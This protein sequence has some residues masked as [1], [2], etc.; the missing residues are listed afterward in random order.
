MKL[1]IYMDYSATTPVDPRVAEKMIPYLTEKFGNPASRSHAFGWEADE[2]VE[3]A[4]A[5][6]AALVN[7]DP[8]EIVW[9]SGATESNNLAIKGAAHFYQGKGKHIVTMRIEHKAVIDTVRELEREGFSATYLDPEPSGLLDL[10]KF[11][12]ALRPDTVLV[13][14]M[15]VNNE[16]GVVQD[17]AALGEICRERGI[18]FHVDAAQATGKVD[19]DLQ[20]L[21][22]DLMSFSA[23][24]TYGPK[25][26]GAL[27]VRRKPRVRLEAQMHGGGHERGMRSGT[28]ATHQI[29][30]MGEAF[31]IAKEEMAQENER[32]RMLRDRLLKG[33]MTMEEVHI[34]GDMEHR[35]PHNLNLSFNFVEGESLIM[36]IKDVAVSSGSACTSASLEPSYVLR[37]LGRSDELAHS[38]IRFSV[39]RFTTVEEVDYVIE[40]LQGK[41]GKLR[42]LS[43]LWEMYKDGIDLNTVQ[44]AAH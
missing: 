37:A 3:Q 12:A 11:K 32:V 42:E 13:S 23:H 21:K 16:I 9:T 5:Q 18:L 29:V 25:G 41:I 14:I 20:Q 33:L 15:F 10:E 8:K 43:P 44:W 30:G 40:L 1:P 24:K 35:V 6:V 36:A 4:R 2:A 31:R 27:Y 26:I 34:N 39:G 17:I 38:S 28:L 19:I 22:V 7:A